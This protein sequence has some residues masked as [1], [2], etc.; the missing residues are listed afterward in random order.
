MGRCMVMADVGCGMSDVGCRISD[1][2][3][4]IGIYINFWVYC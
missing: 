1:F 3:L 2:G 4:G